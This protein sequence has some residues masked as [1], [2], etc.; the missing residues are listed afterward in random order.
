MMKLI[1][2]WCG[3]LIRETPGN[4]E[5]VSHGICKACKEKE[6]AKSKPQKGD[7]NG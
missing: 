1:C 3:T 7:Q 5:L 2:A 6:M 4:P